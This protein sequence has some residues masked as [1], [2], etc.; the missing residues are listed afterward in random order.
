MGSL[1]ASTAV[2]AA[3]VVGKHSVKHFGMASRISFSS[4]AITDHPMPVIG[5]MAEHPITVVAGEWHRQRW[6]DLRR[7]LVGGRL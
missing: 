6:E 4:T 1:K 5:F 7:Q 2:D 3:V